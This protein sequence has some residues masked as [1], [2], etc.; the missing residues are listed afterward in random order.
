[1][2]F[3]GEIYNYLDLAARWGLLVDSYDTDATVALA[4]FQLHGPRVFAEFDGMFSLAI[5]DRDTN[6]LHVA[7]DRFGEKSV[8]YT[9]DE[10]GFY[11]ASEVRGLAA[12][13][14]LSKTVR[15]DWLA[16]EA[17][18]GDGTP[19]IGVDMVPAASSLTIDL[20]TMRLKTT[21]YWDLGDPMF[22]VR[23]DS[24][25]PS[26]VGDLARC[27]ISSRACDQRSALLLSGG[28]DSAVLALSLRPELLLTVQYD[29]QPQLNE[30]DNARRVADAADRELVVVRP[31]ASQFAERA[32]ELVRR[33]EYPLGNAS[34]FNEMLAYEAVAQAGVRVV[35]GGLG[36][37]ELLLG[38]GRHLIALGTADTSPGADLSPYRPMQERFATAVASRRTAAERYL[39]MVLRSE[40]LDARSRMAVYSEFMRATDLGRALTLTDLAISFPA[41]VISS[42]KLS[43]SFGLERRSPYLAREFAEATYDLPLDAKTSHELGSKGP[44]RDYARSIGVP[45]SVWSDRTKK[46]FSSPVLEWL[47]GEL[48]EWFV[49]SLDT[50]LDQPDV[51]PRL[52][53]YLI[54][55]RSGSRGAFDR[56]GLHAVML[57]LWWADDTPPVAWP[58]LAEQ[59]SAGS[60]EATR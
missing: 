31:T 13:V 43:S 48:H 55:A 44:L 6:Q 9:M 12:V 60:C 41:Q 7:R 47:D 40:D 53:D 32:L 39:A 36:P 14:P 26:S 28:L 15:T 46:G 16:V 52:R 42:D 37:D 17:L 34:P 2:T 22:H 51:P 33:L 23:P 20:A 8:Y 11:L 21:T 57:A 10:K 45:P 54:A 59:A 49:D 50:C 35:F 56:R 4:A 29:E 58:A 30:L 1:M 25:S 3:N 24:G 27:A 18:T 5:Y 19:Y 38:Y